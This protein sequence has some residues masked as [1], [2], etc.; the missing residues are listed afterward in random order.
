MKEEREREAEPEKQREK[1]TVKDSSH[2]ISQS[3][4]YAAGQI[5]EAVAEKCRHLNIVGMVGSIDNDFC[6]T[7]MTIGTDSALHRIIEAVDAISTTASRSVMLGALADSVT[8]D[9]SLTLFSPQSSGFS[10]WHLHDAQITYGSV[11]EGPLSMRNSRFLVM[12]KREWLSE[13]QL[14]VVPA[15]V[16]DQKTKHTGL[17]APCSK[18]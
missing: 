1:N 5:E 4:P 3:N 16:N 9:L 14:L 18:L 11:C 7:D 12:R 15:L 6:G 2:S 17:W 13:Q 8:V 10:L